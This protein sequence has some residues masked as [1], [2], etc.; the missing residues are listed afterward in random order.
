M[1][2][3]IFP[4]ICTVLRI[5]ITLSTPD[6]YINVILGY[7]WPYSESFCLRHTHS[8]L[9]PFHLDSPHYDQLADTFFSQFILDRT[10]CSP[11][12]SLFREFF[13]FRIFPTN[14]PKYKCRC[15]FHSHISPFPI[16]HVLILKSEEK[17]NGWMTEKIT[18]WKL[19]G[20]ICLAVQLH[21]SRSLALALAASCWPTHD[22]MCALIKNTF[23]KPHIKCDF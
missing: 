23:I 16:L 19:C 8:N 4:N 1:F 10:Y 15:V 20:N 21:S 22:K 9:R 18:K 14:P 17:Y 5:N 3:F 7:A 6:M 11:H 12:S 2:C 13:A